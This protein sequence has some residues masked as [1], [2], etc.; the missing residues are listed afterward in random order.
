MS[1]LRCGCRAG[2]GVAGPDRFADPGHR[3]D[4]RRPGAGRTDRRRHFPG[5]RSRDLERRGT[6]SRAHPPPPRNEPGTD[7]RS[8]SRPGLR[9]A[10]QHGRC[11]QAA[12]TLG[13]DA[14]TATRPSTASTRS[15][16][17]SPGSASAWANPGVPGRLV[18]SMRERRRRL[19]DQLHDLPRRPRVLYWA[20]GYTAGRGTTIDDIIREAG[21]VNVAAELGLEGSPEISP[22]RV[23]AADPEIV[24]L[25]AGRPRNARARSGTTRSSVSFQPCVKATW[26]RSRGDISRA[27]RHTWSPGPSAW[28]GRCI[29]AASALRTDH[30]QAA[31]D[32][33]PT[34]GCRSIHQANSPDYL[35]NI[36]NQGSHHE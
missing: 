3:R 2:A 27:S 35:L 10:L 12:G 18:E 22:E 19:A 7:R 36:T 28:P 31:R 24:L 20:A 6:L 4:A 14:S 16:P 26:S 9:G 21:G 11:A 13:A 33:S 8:H 34:F 5:R 17:A 30:D 32:P 25:R 23:V 29:P 1:T 15:R